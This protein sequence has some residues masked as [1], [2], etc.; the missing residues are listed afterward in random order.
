M[1]NS[2]HIFSLLSDV[3]MRDWFGEYGSFTFSLTT[4][5]GATISMLVYTFGMIA[6]CLASGSVNAENLSCHSTAAWGITRYF[7]YTGESNQAFDPSSH[8]LGRP[9]LREGSLT[10][11]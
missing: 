6:V 3:R 5:G 4:A 1:Y 10:A 8:V 9:L 11:W 2:Q 7:I